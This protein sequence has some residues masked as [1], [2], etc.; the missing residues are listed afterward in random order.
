MKIAHIAI[1]VENLE[2]MR[3]FYQTYFNAS[4]N[5]KYINPAKGFA[6]Y[7]LSFSEGARL[8]LMKMHSIPPRLHNPAQ[9]HTGLVHFA[10]ALGSKS[11]VDRLTTRLREDGYRIV[12]GPR[13]TGD[14]YYESVILDP[15]GNR[16]ELTV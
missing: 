15:E 11:A 12:D 3:D 1:W 13:T 9:Q 10:L 16:I 7:F 5:D 8:E 4:S 2:L 6:S 14:G